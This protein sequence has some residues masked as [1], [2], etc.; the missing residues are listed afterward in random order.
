MG[1]GYERVYGSVTVSAKWATPRVEKLNLHCYAA[2]R[3]VAD[4]SR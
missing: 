1:I 2:F 4:D 3:L